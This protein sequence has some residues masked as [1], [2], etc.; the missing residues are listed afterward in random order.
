MT[1]ILVTGATGTVGGALTP[2]LLADGHHVRVLTRAA[3]KLADRDWHDDVEIVEGDASDAADM[4]RALAG[5]EVAYYLVHG[6]SGADERTLVVEEVTVAETFLRAAEDAGVRRIVYLGG[7]LGEV[8]LEDLS[9]HL[10]SRYEVG[11]ALADGRDVEVVELRAALVIGAGSSS[12]RMLEAVA[13]ELP[14]TPHT[15]W[16]RTLTQ[17]VALADAV[18][19]LKAGLDLP[20]GVHDIG[21][22]DVVSFEDLVSAYRTAAGLAALPEVDVPLLPRA[23]ASPVAAVLSD[24]DP[25]LTRA[26]I[27]SAEYDT[28]VRPEHDVSAHCDHRPLALTEMLQL[29]QP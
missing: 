24:L 9:P 13:T 16:T 3:A 21:G 20:P 10:R 27:A 11:R 26:L 19:Y 1:T 6:L 25:A 7:L 5:T 4:T 29:A 2:A 28:L 8:E 17:P 18:E 14:I 12:Y 23:V 15:D 22:P